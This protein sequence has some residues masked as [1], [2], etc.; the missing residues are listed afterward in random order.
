M[1][2][3]MNYVRENAE[4]TPRQA[5]EAAQLLWEAAQKVDQAAALINGRVKV[6]LLDRW[7]KLEGRLHREHFA[8]ED[9]FARLCAIRFQVSP[10]EVPLFGHADNLERA[11]QFLADRGE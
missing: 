11:A 9:D 8:L 10:R 7:Q 4:I 3:K 1:P 6:S 5:L 2:Y